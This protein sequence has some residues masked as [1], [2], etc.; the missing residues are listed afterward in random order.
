MECETMNA[1]IDKWDSFWAFAES[2][3]L[4]V[5]SAVVLGS[6]I[7]S[8]TSGDP[9]VIVVLIAGIVHLVAYAVIGLPLF[10]IYW[11]KP[12]SIVWK[13]YVALPLGLILGMTPLF[14]IDPHS[15][16]E[17]F[18]IAGAYGVVSTVATLWINK[19]RR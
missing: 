1:K 8:I 6:L 14:I 9:N 11:P 18:L 7:S 13:W 15:Q 10:L 19:K 16:Y 5:V 3:V 2:G 17:L 4:S 12:R